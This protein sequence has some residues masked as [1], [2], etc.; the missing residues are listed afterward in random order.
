MKK[1]IL[2]LI[3]VA[4]TVACGPVA[5]K[6]SFDDPNGKPSQEKL[7]SMEDS[8][9]SIARIESAVALLHNESASVS[10][11]LVSEIKNKINTP[12]CVIIFNRPTV[13]TGSRVSEMKISGSKCA[14]QAD[15]IVS[16]QMQNAN[17]MGYSLK[18]NFKIIDPL[19]KAKN[20]IYEL[21]LRGIGRIRSADKE[22]VSNLSYT[23][24]VVSTEAGKVSID[25]KQHELSS[26][27]NPSFKSN[28]Y[29]IYKFSFPSVTKTVGEKEVIV[30]GYQIEVKKL[31]NIT[32]NKDNSRYLLNEESINKSD[33][34]SYV[35]LFGMLGMPN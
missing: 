30:P 17:V 19:L 12:D 22:L 24:S 18:A 21:S 34:D 8:L 1:L 35:D 28:G 3:A 15:Y 4:F 33:Y 25:V 7:S 2:G 14:I 20:H 27:L 10:D 32:Q 13:S 26:S 5:K 11:D 9:D 6:D 31:K 23:G 29:T 16:Y